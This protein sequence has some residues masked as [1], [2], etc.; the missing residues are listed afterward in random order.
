[1]IAKGIDLWFVLPVDASLD[2]GLDIHDIRLDICL[3]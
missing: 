3:D 2:V 1:M